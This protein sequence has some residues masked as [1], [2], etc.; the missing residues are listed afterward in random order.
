MPRLKHVGKEKI[1]ET[2]LFIVQTE[3]IDSLNARKIANYLSCSTQPIYSEF[4]SMDD[5]KIALKVEAENTYKDCVS[6][7]LNNSK[8]SSY[9]SVGMGY[10]K[11]A[12]EHKGLF[13]FLYMQAQNQQGLRFED[14]N[15]DQIRYILTDVYQLTEKQAAEYHLEMAIYTYGL[16]CAL[17]LDLVHIDEDEVANR[18]TNQ[19]NAL[20]SLYKK[21]QGC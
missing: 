14:V 7:Y 17:N 5:L 4:K 18:L 16:A 20:M 19:F 2:S 6:Y 8:Y 11:F 1:L 9:L 10:V 13:N 12:K 3:G 21:E 15:S